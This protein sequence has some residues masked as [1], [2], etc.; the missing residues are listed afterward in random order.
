LGFYL[1]KYVKNG[2][3]IQKKREEGKGKKGR[4]EGKE[5]RAGSKERNER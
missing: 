2:Y 1:E 5:Q 3:P 4:Q